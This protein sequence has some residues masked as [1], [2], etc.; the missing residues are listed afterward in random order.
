VLNAG[1]FGWAAWSP[2]G[3]EVVVPGPGFLKRLGPDDRDQGDAKPEPNGG[4]V[5][6]PG[7]A[8]LWQPAA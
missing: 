2:D 6:P 4:V 8:V 5:L 1:R 7:G 3:A